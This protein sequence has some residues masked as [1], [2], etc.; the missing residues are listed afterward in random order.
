MKIDVRQ[1]PSHKSHNTEAF[2][3]R[4]QFCNVLRIPLVDVVSFP[5]KPSCQLIPNNKA[6]SEFCSHLNFWTDSSFGSISSLP[7]LG[8]TLPLRTIVTEEKWEKSNFQK[9]L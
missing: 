7:T 1:P 3:N 5:Y 4:H 8:Q 2:Q 9:L 6:L